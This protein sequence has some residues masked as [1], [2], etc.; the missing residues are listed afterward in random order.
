MKPGDYLLCYLTRVSR[1]V[2]VLE[3]TGEPFFDEAPI[4]SSQVFPSRVSVRVVLAVRPEHGVP[5]LDMRGELTVFQDLDNPN[6][7][8]GPFRGSPTRW[9][10]ADGEAVVRSLHE[11]QANPVARPLGRL[12]KIRT[13]PAVAP[14][15]A[16]GGVS[17]PEDDEPA[18]GEAPEAAASAH[19]EIRYL[20]VKLG[21]EMGF[22]VHV[23]RND[24]SRVWQG[25][26]LGT[27]PAAASS[28]PCSSTR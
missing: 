17:V 23:A 28:F 21:A 19:T 8:Q 7:W 27:C 22:D 25:Q 11:A 9:K 4:W 24:Q 5:V 15:S 26:R 2:G 1:W 6:R 3:V 14:G 13:K 10:A 12:A 20:L 18:G 16:G